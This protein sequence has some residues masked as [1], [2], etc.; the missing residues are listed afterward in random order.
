MV[1][2]MSGIMGGGAGGMGGLAGMGSSPSG[3]IGSVGLDLAPYRM[4][5]VGGFFQDP[6]ELFMKEQLQRA[7]EAYSAYRPEVAQAQMNAL[8][9]SQSAYQ[10]ANDTLSSMMGGGGGVDASQ[11]AQNP[12]SPRMMELGAPKS[13]VHGG[14]AGS[15]PGS[16]GILGGLM[17]GGGG[18]GLLG[19]M[20][21]ILG[22]K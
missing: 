5:I 18:G 16:S 3:P 11:M 21:G 15:G 9:A 22:G 7:G 14:G 19:G 6:N 8:R 20:G 4:P 2:A 13:M 1:D 10:P 17:G 12:M